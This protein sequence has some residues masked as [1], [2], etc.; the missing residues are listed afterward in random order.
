MLKNIDA[1]IFDLD[2]TLINSM[3]VWKHV[4]EI[5]MKKYQITQPNDFHSVMEGMSY[6]EVAAYFRDTFQLPMTVEEIKQEWLDMSIDMYRNDVQLKEGVTEFLDYLQSRNIKIGLA[7]SCSMAHVEAVLEGRQIRHYF[8]ALSTSCAVNAG[9]PAPDVYLKA[10][11]DMMVDP[12]HCLTFEDVPKG[13]MAGKNA[14]MTTCAVEDIGNV[15]QRI[16]L[17]ELANYYITTFHDVIQNTYE[18]L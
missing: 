6:T 3:W 17:R 16:E 7:T 14:G 18:V 1:V 10:A 2:G 8:H 12:S 9:K 11:Q 15:K 13:I 5:Y 4:D